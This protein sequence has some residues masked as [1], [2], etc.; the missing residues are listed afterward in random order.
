MIIN[1]VFLI[2]NPWYH[3]SGTMCNTLLII[4]SNS[5]KMIQLRPR[6]SYDFC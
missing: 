6:I 4:I 3:W 1:K 2:E 5:L